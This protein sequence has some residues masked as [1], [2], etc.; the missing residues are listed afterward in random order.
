MFVPV[1]RS[2]PEDCSVTRFGKSLQ[3]EKHD[4]DQHNGTLACVDN[5][6]STP[7]DFFNTQFRV[8]TIT[9]S[10][11]RSAFFRPHGIH[12]NAYAWEMVPSVEIKPFQVRHLEN[13]H[14]EVQPAL[15]NLY[16]A[17]IKG[18]AIRA[19]NFSFGIEI[20]FERLRNDLKL[21]DLTPENV[22]RYKDIIRVHIDKIQFEQ[23]PHL[24]AFIRQLGRNHKS[25][26]SDSLDIVQKVSHI[27]DFYTTAANH[28]RDYFNLYLATDAIGV[29]S[30]DQS[31]NPV[32]K[33][34]NNSLIKIWMPLNKVYEPVLGEEL[35]LLGFRLTIPSREAI[36]DGSGFQFPLKLRPSE[37][38]RVHI[39]A[40]EA[41][42]QKF[43]D[44]VNS[45]DNDNLNWS[46]PC[47]TATSCASPQAAA[48][49]ASLTPVSK[50]IIKVCN[51]K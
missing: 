47:Y 29:G 42:R 51:D 14:Y 35:Q 44:I 15:E 39:P 50:P 38:I 21:S 2:L 31:G 3:T 24:E 25:K 36:P 23:I 34:G 17:L 30:C 41:E 11:T 49:A 16:R 33:S 22:L 8:G 26:I 40:D 32:P 37:N 43:Q 10:Y 46:S 6:E 28:G 7:S 1:F 45:T 48:I 19:A 18:I 5:F 20:P 27:T 13:R 4:H 12:V 9:N